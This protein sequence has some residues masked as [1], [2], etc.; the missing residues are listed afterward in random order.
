MARKI[1]SEELARNRRESR[2]RMNAA[3]L[4]SAGNIARRLMELYLP[5]PGPNDFAFDYSIGA[6]FRAPKGTAPSAAPQLDPPGVINLVKDAD[7]G[8]WK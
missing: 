1:I 3:L 2:D 7:T 6:Q 4:A 8:E 5:P